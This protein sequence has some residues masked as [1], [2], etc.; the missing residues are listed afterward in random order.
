MRFVSGVIIGIVM[1]FALSAH[2]LTLKKSGV[3]MGWTVIKANERICFD[4]KVTAAE[5][6]IECD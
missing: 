6:E 3:L 2:A 1:G 4:P 5:K